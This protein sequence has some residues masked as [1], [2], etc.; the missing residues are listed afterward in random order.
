[1]NLIMDRFGT[2]IVH[3]L[4]TVPHSEVEMYNYMYR[5]G[6]RSLSIVYREVVHCHYEGFHEAK[7][8]SSKIITFL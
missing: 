4:E 8:V 5:Q 2:S 3:C 7:A 1:M 6:A